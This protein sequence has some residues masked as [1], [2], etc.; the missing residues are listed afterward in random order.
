MK[1]LAAICAGCAAAF[2]AQAAC[3][4]ELLGLIGAEHDAAPVHV[5]ISSANAAALGD[6][7]LV[8]A[9]LGGSN[10]YVYGPEA[11]VSPQM[12]FR[13]AIASVQADAFGF[14]GSATGGDRV[15]D[16]G[17]EAALRISGESG[18]IE[19]APRFGWRST[20]SDNGPCPEWMEF[21]TFCASAAIEAERRFLL[22]TTNFADTAW[23][24]YVGVAMRFDSGPVVDIA[25]KNYNRAG[26]EIAR[27]LN[28]EAEQF[29]DRG[30][31]M[32]LSVPFGR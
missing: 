2:A 30:V 29:G 3:G 25:Y 8:V 4:Q 28:T 16:I 9:T 10:A 32:S 11:P 13:L 1:R 20:A 31:V 24:T 26:A 5:A 19:L 15:L 21:A 17:G 18:G 6:A 23:R 14:G 7:H 12:Q 27:Q 22:T